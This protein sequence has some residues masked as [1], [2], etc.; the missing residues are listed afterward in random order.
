MGAQRYLDGL[1]ARAQQALVE[2]TRALARFADARTDP[3]LEQR[4][5]RVWDI[6]AKHALAERIMEEEVLRSQRLAAA[7]GEYPPHNNAWDAER[8]ARGTQRIAEAIGP[9][10]AAAAGVVHEGLNLA[11]AVGHGYSSLIDGEPNSYDRSQGIFQT[12]REIPMDLRN[13]GEGLRAVREGRAIDPGRLQ[14]HP[15]ALGR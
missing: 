14:T 11:Q 9:T 3:T 12:L 10:A 1:R 15:R 2:N 7:A 5:L 6:P 13:N 4:A 8:H